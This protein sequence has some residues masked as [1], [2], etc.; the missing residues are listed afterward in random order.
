MKIRQLHLVSIILVVIFLVSCT[1]SAPTATPE[2][3]K[4]EW[5][6]WQGDYTAVIAQKMGFF[7]QRGVE[8][9]LV[10]YDSATKSLPDLAGAKLDG[11][12][13][14]MTDILLASNLVDLR[15]V[16]ATDNGGAYSIVSSQ[17]IT[18]V[19]DLRRKRIG[20]NLHTASE[21]FLANML[22][23]ANISL[24]DVTLVEM[25][26]QQVVESIPDK[27]DAGLVWE[28]YTSMALEKGENVL[29]QNAEYSALFPKL[30]TFRKDILEKRPEDVRAFL[31]AWNDAISF[32]IHNPSEA[33][34]VLSVATGLPGS[35]LA[36]TDNIHL[37]DTQKNRE[38]FFEQNGNQINSIYY[39]ARI[40]RE[41]LINMGYITNPP[42]IN[43]LLDPSFLK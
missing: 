33:T 20:L 26:P 7:K 23:T 10:R 16:M 41:T 1:G 22:S 29:Y 43:L 11:G 4:V 36:L 42:D 17:A 25:D 31:L 18:S 37:Y 38:I 12:I 6:F 30:I 35:D 9:Q 2:P 13:Y 3:L 19:S 15:S 40:N 14:T 39:I 27:I 24:Y 32:R 5:S 28:P 34:A 8:V 21:T